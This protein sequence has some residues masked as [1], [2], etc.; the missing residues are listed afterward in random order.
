MDRSHAGSSSLCYQIQTR[1][2]KIGVTVRVPCLLHYYSSNLWVV[3]QLQ[4]EP[5]ASDSTVASWT[6]THLTIF[7]EERRVLGR[8]TFAISRLSE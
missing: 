6:R 5:Q 2:L 1:R 7:G 8:R 3:V 4:K